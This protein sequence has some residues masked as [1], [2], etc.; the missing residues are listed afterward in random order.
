VE[1]LDS[2]YGPGALASGSGKRKVELKQPRFLPASAGLPAKPSPNTWHCLKCGMASDANIHL[3]H[4]RNCRVAPIRQASLRSPNLSSSKFCSSDTTHDYSDATSQES[5]DE[6]DDDDDYNASD[7]TRIQCQ[8]RIS[9][10]GKK[11]TLADIKGHNN[12]LCRQWMGLDDAPTTTKFWRTVVA[13]GHPHLYNVKISRNFRLNNSSLLRKVLSL[14]VFAVEKSRVQ[15]AGFF[16]LDR[17]PH[18]VL[19]ERAS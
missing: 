1:Y 18:A 5:D 16:G 15:V 12:D 8:K 10:H 13:V 17:N 3:H 7:H 19:G 9:E 14:T 6:L 2:D 4:C 11:L